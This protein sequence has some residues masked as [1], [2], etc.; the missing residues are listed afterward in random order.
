[1]TATQ[2]IHAW[3]RE[4]LEAF[5][6]GGL[7]TE[8]RGKLQAHAA[9]CAACEVALNEVKQADAALRDLFAFVAPPAD[10]E[11]ALVANLSPRLA[12]RRLIHPTLWRAMTGIA[13]VIILGGFGLIGSRVLQD[14]KVPTLSVPSFSLLSPRQKVG[15]SQV[16]Y[17]GR[18]LVGYSNE[19]AS[20]QPAQF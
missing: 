13:A 17:E 15:R 19:S 4:H 10:Y 20:T 8:D 6:A 9:V 5:C 7:S 18:A 1:M 11:D 2:D 14:G 3:F 16:N 12:E